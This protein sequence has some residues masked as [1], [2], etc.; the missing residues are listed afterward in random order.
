MGLF[1]SD[2]PAVELGTTEDPTKLVPGKASGAADKARVFQSL[3]EGVDEAAAGLKKLDEGAWSGEAAEAYRQANDHET[4][5]WSDTAAAFAAAAQALTD[6]SH[7]ITAAQNNAARAIELHRQAET[8]TKKAKAQHNQQAHAAPAGAPEM[9]FTD[10]GAGGRAEAE[11][12]LHQARAEMKTSSQATAQALQRAR[13]K[14]PD[15]SALERLWGSVND[16]VSP[17]VEAGSGVAG[18]IGSALGE[19]GMGALSTVAKPVQAFLHPAQTISASADMAAGMVNQMATGQ[20]VTGIVGSADD[21]K[22]DPATAF[23]KAWTN[24]GSMFTGGGAAAKAGSMVGK[25]GRAAGHVDSPHTPH[26]TPNAHTS[27]APAQ[28]QPDHGLDANGEPSR[29]TSAPDEQ[30]R[31]SQTQQPPST[32][33]PPHPMDAR[34]AVEPHGQNVRPEQRPYS[35]TEPQLRDSDST[36]SDGRNSSGGPDT[37]REVPG[38]TGQS[39]LG[40]QPPRPVDRSETP[41]IDRD[42]ATHSTPGENGREQQSGEQPSQNQQDKPTEQHPDSDRR[43]DDQHNHGEEDPENPPRDGDEDTREDDDANTDSP[44]TPEPGA[45]PE[46]DSMPLDS[47]YE[48][49]HLPGNKVFGTAVHY[50]DEI[51][52][53]DYKLTV[54]EDGLL[55]DADGDLFDT[56]DASSLHHPEGGRAIFVMDRNGD[57]YASSYQEKGIFHHSSFLGGEPVAAAGELGVKDGKVHLISN[58]SGHY[59]P[60]EESVGQFMR[61]LFKREGAELDLPNLDVMFAKGS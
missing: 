7:T 36:L 28:A 49:E 18:G 31:P 27:A 50:L 1:S 55:R 17:L 26:H 30:V 54:G 15:L 33:P 39:D 21:W 44:H 48:G 25:I 52:R 13:E 61:H 38:R 40:E 23:G 4:P 41:P 2:T 32:T 42:P 24:V 43:P 58:Q 57:L 53:Q 9:P 45:L 35:F 14:L 47:K 56:R 60:P 20:I 46:Y 29:R 51:E 19:M 8:A 59:K 16:A 6:H 11:A 10:P 37:P 12:I 34:A 5:R 22:K 3:S